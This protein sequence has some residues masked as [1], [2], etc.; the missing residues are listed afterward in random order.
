MIEDVAQEP[1]NQGAT[2]TSVSP[3]VLQQIS[4]GH[5]KLGPILKEQGKDASTIREWLALL[6]ICRFINNRLVD[7]RM[8]ALAFDALGIMSTNLNGRT[9]FKS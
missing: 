4:E 8:L 6:G 2:I 5:R 9:Y 1:A 7:E 3:E